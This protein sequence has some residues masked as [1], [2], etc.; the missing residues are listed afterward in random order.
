MGRRKGTRGRGKFSHRRLGAD[1]D[2]SFVAGACGV[3]AESLSNKVIGES[4]VTFPWAST[5]A[6][7]DGNGEGDQGQRE[8]QGL[9][10]LLQKQEQG[11]KKSR[12]T[13]ALFNFES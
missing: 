2:A 7:A 10:G 12:F 3:D 11:R 4:S 6:A 8:I 9:Q 13:H 1:L 5:I